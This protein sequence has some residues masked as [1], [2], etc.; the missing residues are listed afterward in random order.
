M[1]YA[2]TKPHVVTCMRTLLHFDYKIADSLLFVK[3]AVFS[4]M[5]VIR[6]YG[7]YWHEKWKKNALRSVAF[8][9]YIG[10]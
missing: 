10:H 1:S 6:S 2:E 4:K 9:S 8:G 7:Q 5:T 3:F